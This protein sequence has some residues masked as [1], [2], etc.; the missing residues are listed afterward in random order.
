[1]IGCA[2]NAEIGRSDASFLLQERNAIE[3]LGQRADLAFSAHFGSF[4]DREIV[5]QVQ[6]LVQ[7]R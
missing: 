4:I 1:M 2:G 5:A 6:H 7:T 3:C